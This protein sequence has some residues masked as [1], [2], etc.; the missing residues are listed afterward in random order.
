MASQ[1]QSIQIKATLHTK[2]KIIKIGVEI[3][4]RYN[5]MSGSANINGSINAHIVSV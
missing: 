2:R 1:E 3:W 5:D 4:N